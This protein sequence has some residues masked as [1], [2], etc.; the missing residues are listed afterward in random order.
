MGAWGIGSFENDEALDWLS[1]LVASGDASV[2]ESALAAADVVAAW[3]GH[4]AVR[5]TTHDP[6]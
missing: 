1:D 5:I 6:Q 3:N 2:I 4:P